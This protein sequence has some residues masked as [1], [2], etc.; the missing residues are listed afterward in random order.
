MARK[1]QEIPGTEPKRI[2]RVEDRA[3]A[4]RLIVRDRLEMQTKEAE[5]KA[6]LEREINKQIEAGKLS[7]PP[8]SDEEPVPI[9]RYQSDDGEMVIRW[10]RTEQVRVGKA[11]GK[12]NEELAA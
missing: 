3:E 10:G 4:Y 12:A 1:Q 11:K 8:G 5:A 9:Y 7:V 2:Q 6:D